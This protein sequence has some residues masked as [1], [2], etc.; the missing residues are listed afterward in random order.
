M[1][2][3]LVIQIEDSLWEKVLAAAKKEGISPEGLVVRI[4]EENLGRD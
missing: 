3:P 1:E 4:L 2:H